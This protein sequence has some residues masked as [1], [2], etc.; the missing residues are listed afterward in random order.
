[1]AELLLEQVVNGIVAGS[2][3]ALVAAGMTM[4]FGV[5]RAIN[6]AH[7]EYYMLGTFSAWWVITRLDMPY[8]ASIFLA[9]ATTMAIAAVIGRLVMQRLVTTPF[10]SGVLATLGLSL[11]LQNAVIL[12]FGGTYK[13]FPGGW[14]EPVE[15]MD[16]SLAQQRIAIVAATIA[17][18]AVLEY[19]VRYT[20]MG[21]SIRAVSQN[22]DCCAVNGIDVE[23]VVLSTF[24]MGTGLAALSGVLTGPINVSIYGGMGESITLKTFAVIVMGGMGNVRGTLFAGWILGIAESFVAGYVGMQYR[25]AV[26]FVILIAMLMFR[27]QG[28]FSVQAR[29]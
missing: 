12:S 28:F 10:Q 22:T 4:I 13:V 11:I 1:M 21:K 14:L 7:G 3:Y 20:R 26:G 9:V 25:D 5:L 19:V 24:V 15:F 16:M 18:F 8:V 2:V 29:F 27:P 17:V 6:F 23:R